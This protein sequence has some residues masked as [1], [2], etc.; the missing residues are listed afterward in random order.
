MD[1]KKNSQDKQNNIDRRKK[2]IIDLSNFITADDVK[3]DPY[4]SWT[5]TTADTYYG[6]EMDQPVQD[7]DDL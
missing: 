7:A 6:N 5:G 2:K 1:S 3:Y 4:G